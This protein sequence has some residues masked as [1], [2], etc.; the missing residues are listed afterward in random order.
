[1]CKIKQLKL[2]YI[3]IKIN[4]QKPQDKKTTIISI[5]FRI[6]QAIKVLYRK[7]QH[8]NQRLYYLHLEGAHHYNDKLP[9]H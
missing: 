3:N 5:R 2:N 4:G 6:N 8:V 9:Q 7:K 1:M